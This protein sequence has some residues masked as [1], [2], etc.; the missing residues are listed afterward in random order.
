MIRSRIS[1]ALLLILPLAGGW[2]AKAAGELFESRGFNLPRAVAV[3]DYNND[4]IRDL[5]VVHS[6]SDQVSILLGDG[7][8]GFQPSNYS[9]FSVT[10]RPTSLAAAQLDGVG[11]FDLLVV[12]NRAGT[13]STFTSNA[14]NPDSSGL[15]QVWFLL[16]SSFV[17]GIS[18]VSVIAAHFN[19]DDG[20]GTPGSPGDFI[21]AAVT[22]SAQDQVSILAGLTNGNFDINGTIPATDEPLPLRPLGTDLIISGDFDQDGDTDL[23]V[24][25]S[26]GASATD[27]SG[28]PENKSL[29]LLLGN[30]DLTFQA[31]IFLDT[32]SGCAIPGGLAVNNFNKDQDP[33]SG[34]Q[35]LDLAV[36]FSGGFCTG[37]TVP[38]P[39]C[40]Q[41]GDCPSGE[42]CQLSEQV[43]VFLGD[44]AEP[45]FFAAPTLLPLA[46]GSTP[47][48]ILAA[49]LDGDTFIDLALANNGDDTAV[50]ILNDGAGGF[51]PPA[52]IV[53]PAPAPAQTNAHEYDRP[54]AIAPVIFG[55][56]GTPIDLFVAHFDSDNA[57]RLRNQSTPGTVDF[58]VDTAVST[59][60]LLGPV[61]LASGAFFSSLSEDLFATWTGPASLRG[62]ILRQAAPETLPQTGAFGFVCSGDYT[63]S[64]NPDAACDLAGGSCLFNGTAFVCT[65]D[66]VTPCNVSIDCDMNGFCIRE[67]TSVFPAVDEIGPTAAADFNGDALTD[68]AVAARESATGNPGVFIMLR[69]FGFDVDGNARIFLSQEEFLPTGAAGE[70]IPDAI[71]LDDL[72]PDDN[73]F[74]FI[75]DNLDNCKSTFNPV[76]DC[77]MNP[78]TPDEQCDTDLNGVGDAC[79]DTA[80]PDPCGESPGS[81]DCDA[82]LVDNSIDNCPAVANPTQ[83]DL[84][85]NGIGAACE[86]VGVLDIIAV[87]DADGDGQ[88][89][90]VVFPGRGDGTFCGD[91]AGGFD[92]PPVAT[93][94]PYPAP[95]PA[96]V[97]C[98]Y[99]VTDDPGALATA[100]FNIFDVDFD[101]VQGIFDN[102]PTVPNPSQAN[103]EGICFDGGAPVSPAECCLSAGDCASGT[104]MCEDPGACSAGSSVPN[105]FCRT[106]TNDLCVPENLNGGSLCFQDTDCHATAHCDVTT[107]TEC[108][109][110]GSQ[111]VCPAG[112]ICLGD[113]NGSCGDCPGGVCLA[114]FKGDACSACD[115]D[116]DLDAIFD[117]DDNCPADPIPLQNDSD[118]DGIGDVCEIQGLDLLLGTDSGLTMFT[119]DSKGRLFYPSPVVVTVNSGDPPIGSVSH[120]DIGQIEGLIGQGVVLV[121][122]SALPQTIRVLQSDSTGTMFQTDV[123]DLSSTAVL[124]PSIPM[125]DFADMFLGDLNRDGSEDVF[126]AETTAG[127][128]AA[129]NL[130]EA[131]SCDSGTDCDLSTTG[132]GLGSCMITGAL[133]VAMGAV[134]DLCLGGTNSGNPCVNNI[135]CPNGVC[136]Q[137]QLFLAPGTPFFSGVTPAALGITQFNDDNG[138]GLVGDA[139]DPDI[140][141]ALS[142]AP[143]VLLLSNFLQQRSDINGSGRVDGFDLALLVRDFGLEY[144]P[145]SDPIPGSDLN[146]NGQVD[147]LDLSILTNLFGRSF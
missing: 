9:P 31:P 72:N 93:C 98:S 99:P 100:E 81:P 11:G 68:V 79:E 92:C 80:D 12:Q 34:R 142:G 126:L 60:G 5:A 1:T 115:T 135:D 56:P 2:P 111:D 70:Q 86:R 35:I 145:L 30:N 10:T 15:N 77:D 75:P 147:G 102:C 144:D 46:A 105:V 74:D 6:L 136:G 20:D 143:N 3:A 69:S 58:L 76:S 134:A 120:L 59:T 73:D 117:I 48:G 122:N 64:C 27:S 123:L 95:R 43:A 141:V 61:D 14:E 104:A 129:G 110:P 109:Q 133:V 97:L 42:T 63:T 17:V 13:L 55:A 65:G 146:L 29:S 36:T 57:T 87:S 94:P 24:S 130:N 50:V 125:A 106:S 26:R 83:D 140:V 22:L 38:A 67:V 19:D 128:C 41:D 82:D 51:A 108:F 16:D 124:D 127:S 112:E 101:N 33:G 62:L 52:A 114:R 71:H 39:V 32:C 138:D 107:A 45:D 118:Q 96:N 23:L 85:G 37:T 18:P 66:D 40:N 78:M 132:D 8:G 103:T 139:D 21:D 49:N 84:D 113:D 53:L 131:M 90:A 47:A 4:G 119:G 25:N 137:S 28:L 88:G 44:P 116:S 89:E 91:P 7:A 121:E 54:I